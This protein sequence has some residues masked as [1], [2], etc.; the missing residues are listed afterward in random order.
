MFK[1]ILCFI[2]NR[3]FILSLIVA[4]VAILYIIQLFNLQVINGA[5]YREQS[6][7]R[8]LRNENIIA[9]R[10]EIY[11]RNGIVL[12]TSKLS[13]DV[14]LYKVKVDTK[15]QNDAILNIAN[16][17]E[18]N[19]DRI[20]STFPIKDDM[21][22]FE[23]DDLELEKKWKK[24]VGFDENLSF[25]DVISKY[26]IKFG[27]E[28][29]KEKKDQIK[30]I[31]IKYEANIHGYSLFNSVTIAKDISKKSVAMIEEKKSTLY[32]VNVVS[33]PKRYYPN[34]VLASHSIGYVRNV[35]FEE[36]KNLK[37]QGYTQNSVIGKDGI[38]QTLE[39]YLKRSR[40]NAKS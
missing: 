34:A 9:A 32:G 5:S 28:E 12:A 31:K 26:I 33:V 20:Y 7:K 10:G 13:F 8:M 36:Y 18:T 38:E 21:S 6:E 29:Y 14:D 25:D 3:Y 24:N 1:N 2:N 11:D 40:W 27:L 30:I 23:F 4:S 22:G 16:I 37:N 19:K 17:L 39:K 35:N 15:L